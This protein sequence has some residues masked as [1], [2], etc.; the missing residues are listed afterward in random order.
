M[1]PSNPFSLE[2]MQED[3]KPSLIEALNNSSSIK[4]ILEQ[5]GVLEAIE[6]QLKLNVNKLETQEVELRDSKQSQLRVAI[7]RL[8]IQIFEAACISW[9][10][11]CEAWRQCGDCP[12]N[13]NQC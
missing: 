13:R 11:T 4:E 10:T 6:I 1:E 9:C 3:I 8:N 2:Q 12:A 5:Y 7:T